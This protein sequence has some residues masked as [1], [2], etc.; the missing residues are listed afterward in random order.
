MDIIDPLPNTEIEYQ[1]ETTL[2]IITIFPEEE[3]INPLASVPFAGKN[4]EPV[5]KP[6]CEMIEEEEDE[7]LIKDRVKP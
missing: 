6:L 1:R 7:S 4:K 5:N 3:P 2:N